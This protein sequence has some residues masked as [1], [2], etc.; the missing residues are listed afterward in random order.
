MGHAKAGNA[1][2]AI[3][4]AYVDAFARV[5][6]VPLYRG[7]TL[8]H[9]VESTHHKLRLI[10]MPRPEGWGLKC[11]DLMEELCN[12]IGLKNLTVQVS[13]RRKSKTSVVRALLAALQAAGTPHDGVEGSGTYVREVFHRPNHLPMRLRRGV[14]LP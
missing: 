9:R 12:M 8:Y 14:E 3:A 7:H 4:D 1:Q 10:L 6:A 13:G 11:N 5:I 2:G